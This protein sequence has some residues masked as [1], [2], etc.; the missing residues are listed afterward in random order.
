MGTIVSVSSKMQN[1]RNEVQ[2]NDNCK[3]C[4]QFTAIAY[5]LAWYLH[6]YDLV[7][8]GTLIATLIYGRMRTSGTPYYELEGNDVKDGAYSLW[9]NG[10][11]VEKFSSVA[12]VI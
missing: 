6:L 4:I 3:A 10:Y 12:V 8:V 1:R 2:G 11:H 5:F 9:Y 7:V